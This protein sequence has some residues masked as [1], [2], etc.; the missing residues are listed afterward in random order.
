MK[1]LFLEPKNKGLYYE[2]FSLALKE[3]NEVFQ[4]GPGY[5]FYDSR[6]TIQ[7]ILNIYSLSTRNRKPDLI[8]F[9]FGWED[10]AHPDRFNLHNVDLSMQN[11]NITKAFVV[12]KEYKKLDQ[13]FDFIKQNNID[14]CFTVHHDCDKFQDKTGK[15]FYRMPFA[16]NDKIFKNYNEEK[17]IDLGFS[18][19]MFNS[20]T[21][22]DTP[23]MGKYFQNIRE[24][25]FN[26]LKDP[27]YKNINIWWN[28]NAGNFLF[29][30]DYSRLI[31]SSKIWLNTPSAIEIVGTRFYEVIASNTLLFCRECDWAYDGL[32]FSDGE[33]CVTFKSDLSDFQEKFFYYLNNQ[34]ERE[35]IVTNA[36]NLFLEKHTWSH[37]V[38]FLLEKVNKK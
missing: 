22:K 19:N 33:T 25:I 18:G 38:D 29:G 37:R 1:I 30:E 6:H 36:Y 23:I 8:L 34:Q 32:G 31:N 12:N 26:H 5:D 28:S 2:Q 11:I 24:K 35:K 14:L 20:A 27:M 16:A 21:Y 7:N 15:S 3:K 9:G 17:K 10:D 4:Y 13:K